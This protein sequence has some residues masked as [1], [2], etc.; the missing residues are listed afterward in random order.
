MTT[1][2]VL[3]MQ[4]SAVQECN[5]AVPQ[6]AS[7]SLIPISLITCVLFNISGYLDLS[8]TISQKEDESKFFLAEITL[9]QNAEY[10]V[11]IPSLLILNVK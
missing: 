6:V 9:P 5:M 1:I 8:K 10:E 7:S 4:L 3:C 11:S 2:F